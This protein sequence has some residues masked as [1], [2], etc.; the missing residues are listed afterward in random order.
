MVN[1]KQNAQIPVSNLQDSLQISIELSCEQEK[2]LYIKPLKCRHCLLQQLTSI[3]WTWRKGLTQ[4]RY[5]ES[6]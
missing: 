2:N 6:A 3:T 1:A 4:V 5:S